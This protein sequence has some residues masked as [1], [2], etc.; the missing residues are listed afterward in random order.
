L[1]DEPRFSIR[2]GVQAGGRDRWFEERDAN[3]IMVQFILEHYG[4][5][6]PEN[7]RFDPVVSLDGQ[8]SL[9]IKEIPFVSKDRPLGEYGEYLNFEVWVIGVRPESD[10]ELFEKLGQGVMLDTFISGR[11]RDLDKCVYPLIVRYT[12]RGAE[13]IKKF[14]IEYNPKRY[15]FA[16]RESFNAAA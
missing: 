16:V 4:G 2:V 1:D 5:R 6:V 11:P 14:D 7:I 10:M 3:G 13:R 8:F 12:D 9:R 15:W